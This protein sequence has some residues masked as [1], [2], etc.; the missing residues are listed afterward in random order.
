MA[1]TVRVVVAE[2]SRLQRSILAAIVRARKNFEVLEAENGD[3]AM[4]LIQQQK[5]DIAI[6][7]VEMPGMKGHEICYRM[8]QDPKLVHIPVMIVTA[9][10]QKSAKSDDE[11]RVRFR[12]DDFITKP[13]RSA[14][15]YRRI[16]ALLKGAGAPKEEQGA[17]RW[18]I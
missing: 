8:K 4:A 17:L 14:D 18:R 2:D 9:T 12:A 1:A 3:D 13:F 15:I 10:S 16:D 6:L 5:P 7:D 11:L